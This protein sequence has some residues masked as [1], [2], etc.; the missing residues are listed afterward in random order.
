MV[1]LE[2]GRLTVAAAGLQTRGGLGAGTGAGGIYR[3]NDTSLD[4]LY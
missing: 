4:I 2:D 1:E 3:Q